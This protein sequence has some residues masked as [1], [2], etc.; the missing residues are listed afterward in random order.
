ML[1][2]SAPLRPRNDTAKRPWLLLWLL[3]YLFLS[4]AGA[5]LHNHAPNAAHSGDWQAARTDTLAASVAAAASA[6]LT[7]AAVNEQ[8]PVDSTPRQS[9]HPDCLSCAWAAQSIGL[10]SAASLPTPHLSSLRLASRPR[11]ALFRIARTARHN[12]GPPLS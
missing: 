7:G 5:G 2:P 3:P 11:P 10:L 9:S 4:M 12:R 1:R 8:R 6:P